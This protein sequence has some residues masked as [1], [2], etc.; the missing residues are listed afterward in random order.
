MKKDSQKQMPKIDFSK[1]GEN[2]YFK[3]HDRLFFAYFFNRRPIREPL[4]FTLISFM[5]VEKI[6]FGSAPIYQRSKIVYNIILTKRKP[7][8]HLSLHIN[9]QS[10][11]CVRCWCGRWPR[12]GRQCTGWASPGR[13]P[14]GP[15]GAPCRQ[16][17]S[18][19]ASPSAATPACGW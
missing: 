2:T 9:T 10:V 18:S 15:P 13:S 7:K 6:C 11:S 12:A 19:R 1:K 14:P 3:T 16:T 17:S 4:K 8:L 5:L